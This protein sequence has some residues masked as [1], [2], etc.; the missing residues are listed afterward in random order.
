MNEW[1]DGWMDGWM[2]CQFFSPEIANGKNSAV[3]K[4]TENTKTDDLTLAPRRNWNEMLLTNR[5]KFS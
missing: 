3:P 2:E 1:M 4:P 5:W